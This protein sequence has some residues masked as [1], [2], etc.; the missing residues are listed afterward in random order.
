MDKS[1]GHRRFFQRTVQV[2]SLYALFGFLI[3]NMDQSTQLRIGPSLL[4]SLIPSMLFF[5]T[6]QIT[7]YR[8]TGL[9]WILRHHSLN[10]LGK[11]VFLLAFI[12][13]I[14]IPIQNL[15]IQGELAAI[16]GLVIVLVGTLVSFVLAGWG[17]EVLI[18]RMFGERI[19]REARQREKTLDR[20]DQLSLLRIAFLWIPRLKSSGPK[21]P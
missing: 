4:G 15:V 21:S 3:I 11:L 19:E 13:T 8:R 10:T 7:L 2:F 5:L 20:L 16:W 12:P 18:K 6:L 17:L 9:N 1:I 14:A